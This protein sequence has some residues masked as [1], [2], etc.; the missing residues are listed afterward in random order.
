ML[1]GAFALLA[2]SLLRGGNEEIEAA[3]KYY[4]NTNFGQSL[5]VLDAI[6]DKNAAAFELMGLNYYMQREYKRA[7]E[8]FESA[9][10]L[11]PG[12]SMMALWLGRAY[13]RR[14]ETSSP[15]TAPGFASRARQNFERAV[16]LDEHNLEALSDL[17]EYY[18]DAP[19]F[20]GGGVDKAEASVPRIAAVDPAEG[21]WAQARLAEKRKQMDAAE[22]HL[23]QSVELSPK[24]IG[25]S[26]E[27]ARFLARQ[28]RFEE[29]EQSFAHAERIA[30]GSPRIVFARADVYVKNGRNLALAKQLLERYMSM[31]LTP[32]DPPRADAAKLLKQVQGA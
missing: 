32:D 17:F 30:P 26:L 3:R 23:R 21:H 11:E 14:A 25:P 15:F 10:K 31:S 12:D 28:G 20:L 2:A 22:K 16:Q 8:C 29:A 27:L 9:S 1:A 5:K 24:R 18:L 19:G 4:N 7:A 13:G 6:P